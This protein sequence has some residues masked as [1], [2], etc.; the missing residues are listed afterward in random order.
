MAAGNLQVRQE[1]HFHDLIPKTGT[2]F[3]STI[4]GIERKISGREPTTLGFFGTPKGFLIG[5]Q[6]SE[7]KTGLDRG[8]RTIEL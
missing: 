6:A 4:A 7:Y 1:L 3:A 2:F 8:V 5:P